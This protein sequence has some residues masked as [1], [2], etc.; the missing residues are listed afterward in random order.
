MAR[1]QARRRL[2]AAL[3]HPATDVAVVALVLVSVALIVAEVALSPRSRWLLPVELAGDV[4]TVVFALELTLRWLA[5]GSTREFLRRWWV[6]ILAVLPLLRAFRVFRVLR[7]LRVFRAGLVLNRRLSL[8]SGSFRRT[9]AEAL[10]VG[11][12]LMVLV[13]TG[14]I[15]VH[16]LEG[17]HWYG[18][19]DDSFWWSFL[20]FMSSE[21]IGDVPQSTAG[22]LLTVLVM[23][24]GMTIFAMLTGVVTAAFVQRMRETMTQRRDEIAHL[25]G[26][27]V[28]CGWNRAGDRI[29]SQLLDGTSR[30]RDVVVVAELDDL[31][32]LTVAGRERSRL[33]FLKG[34]Y[35]RLEV[36]EAANIGKAAIAILLA[37]KSHPR[38]DQD[39]D[40]RTVLAVMLIERLNPGI[41]SCVE[42]LNRD[43]EAH[44]RMLGVEEVVVLDD[45]GASLIATASRNDGLVPL[46]NELFSPR[47]NHFCKVDA[48][49]SEIGATVGALV[50]R[51]KAET[52]ALLVAIERPNGAGR[53]RQQIL[54][55]PVGLTIAAGDR[56]VLITDRDL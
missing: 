52:N 22:K 5:S 15:G 49:P 33:W 12:L 21:P 44:L 11:L 10:F 19:F 25:T 3:E 54:N 14:A 28:I 18:S 39:R 40:A 26:H 24:G 47:G 51:L 27:V 37:D 30:Q 34:D 45:Y 20:S 7:L 36:L 53:R 56:L 8:F 2:Q 32:A 43:N 55:P 4:I 6:D 1:D 29:V 42:L 13:L 48:G 41:F 16:M 9:A 23:L 50:P 46:F 31:P 38:S 17:P 35:T